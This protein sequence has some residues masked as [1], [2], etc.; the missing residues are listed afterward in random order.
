MCIGFNILQG[1][2]S[3]YDGTQYLKLINVMKFLDIL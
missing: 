1:F 2:I 3:V